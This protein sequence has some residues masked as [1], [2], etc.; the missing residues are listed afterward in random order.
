MRRG[1]MGMCVRRLGV[2]MRAI[3]GWR[4][5]G[6]VVLLWLVLRGDFSLFILLQ[7]ATLCCDFI[8]HLIIH[9]AWIFQDQIGQYYLMIGDDHR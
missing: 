7:C 8:A 1:V 4:C 5:R 6:L 3:R 2:V 9:G